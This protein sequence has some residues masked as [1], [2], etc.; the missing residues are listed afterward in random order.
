MFVGFWSDWFLLLTPFLLQNFKLRPLRV[1]SGVP[2]TGRLL[3]G[4]IVLVRVPVRAGFVS[5]RNT[6]YVQKIQR[7]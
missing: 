5:Y 1:A 3:P 4:D 2:S 7:P 6:L